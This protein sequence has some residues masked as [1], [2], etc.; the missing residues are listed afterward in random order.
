[1]NSPFAENLEKSLGI[2]RTKLSELDKCSPA[3]IERALRTLVLHACDAQ[4]VGNI[5]AAQDAIAQIPKGLLQNRLL[6]VAEKTL[7]LSDEWHFRRLVELTQEVMPNLTLR[8]LDLGLRSK[9]AEVR[10]AA[11]DLQD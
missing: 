1:M 11:K 3:E 2:S 10:E 9:S 7:D 6:E 8:L 4:H 5:L